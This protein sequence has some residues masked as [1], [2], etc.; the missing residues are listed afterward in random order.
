MGLSKLAERCKKCQ[1]V[2][3]C[4]HKE[5]EAVGFLPGEP[6]LEEQMKKGTA[7]IGIMGMGGSVLNTAMFYQAIRE[8]IMS[9][10]Q[11]ESTRLTDEMYKQINSQFVVPSNL[12]GGSK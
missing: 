2:D 7:K 10:I 9:G 1:Y 3:T 5:M 4:D 12:L 11:L 8:P 6:T